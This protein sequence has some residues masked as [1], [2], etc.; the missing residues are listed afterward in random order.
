MLNP[1]CNHSLQSANALLSPHSSNNRVVPLLIWKAHEA[2]I[3]KAHPRSPLQPHE[4]ST[5]EISHSN[6]A[7]FNSHFLPAP[8]PVQNH[9]KNKTSPYFIAELLI[10]LDSYEQLTALIAL[11]EIRMSCRCMHR[12]TRFF[13]LSKSAPLLW[14]LTKLQRPQDQ[15]VVSHAEEALF[16]VARGRDV[17]ILEARKVNR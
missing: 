14:I 4:C 12:I 16:A 6:H 1:D 3:H 15:P 7:S 10:L 11:H 17:T 9:I 2:H 5:P 8:N 13:E